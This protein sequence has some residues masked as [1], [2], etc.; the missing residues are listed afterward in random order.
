MQKA[1]EPGSTFA[2]IKHNVIQ[3]GATLANHIHARTVFQLLYSY[4]WP[5]DGRDERLSRFWF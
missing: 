1:V 3:Q 5:H 2:A 4:C